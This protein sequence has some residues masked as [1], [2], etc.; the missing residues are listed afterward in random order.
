MSRLLELLRALR[1]DPLHDALA[2]LVGAY[3]VGVAML[4]LGALGVAEEQMT[5][6]ALLAVGAGLCL[7]VPTALAA[8]FDYWDLPK[9]TPARTAATLHLLVMVL[10]TALFALTFALQLEG[11]RSDEVTTGAW[12]AGL[13]ALVLLTAGG[14]IGRALVFPWRR[15]RGGSHHT[16][17]PE[18]LTAGLER[19][20]AAEP[21]AQGGENACRRRWSR[22]PRGAAPRSSD[23]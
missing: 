16:P 17:V 13:G 23:R 14:Y 11:Y 22:R 1:R 8:V 4:L 10:A 21:A 20:A 5:Y 3:T 2:A 9:G 6:G 19:Q 18:G 7:T 15:A 12:I